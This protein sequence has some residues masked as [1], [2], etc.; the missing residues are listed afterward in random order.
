MEREN[1][2][3]SFLKKI[4]IIH[5][6]PQKKPR[7]KKKPRNIRKPRTMPENRI[8]RVETLCLFLTIWKVVDNTTDYF[9]KRRLH[10]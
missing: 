1:E 7:K 4:K 8:P 2:M 10:Y 9:E 3:D 5:I 6:Y